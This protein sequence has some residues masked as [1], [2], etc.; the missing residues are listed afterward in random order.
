MGGHCVCGVRLDI[1]SVICPCIFVSSPGMDLTNSC[2]SWDSSTVAT[3][4]CPKATRLQ[5]AQKLFHI[6]LKRHIL[7]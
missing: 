7:T 2:I 6:I 1:A 4:S 3:S 5:Y